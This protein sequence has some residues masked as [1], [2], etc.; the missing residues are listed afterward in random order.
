VTRLCII[1]LFATVAL[2][3]AGGPAAAVELKGQV[4]EVT[5][6]DVRIEVEGDLLPRVGDPVRIAFR[7]PGGPEVT[8][9]QWRVSA[10][11][12]DGIRGTVAE[13]TGTPAVGQLVTITSEN[14]TRRRTSAAPAPPGPRPGRG[15][16]GAELGIVPPELA[17][18]HALGPDRGA[19]IV[20]VARDGPA[21]RAGIQAGDIVLQAGQ[22]TLMGAL[23]LRVTI[24]AAAPGTQ[25]RFHLLREGRPLELVVTVGERPR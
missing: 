20:A 8:V 22:R 5:G 7:I 25:L 12:V 14:P 6:R 19:L 9:G 3:A 18:Q 21:A 17:A 4:V 24:G 10:V 16:L 1:I 23:D 2:V 11:G 13:A 15:Y